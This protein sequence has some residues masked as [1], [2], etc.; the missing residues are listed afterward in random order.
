SDILKKFGFSSVKSASTPMETHKPLSKDAA[1]TDVDVH[2]YSD[3]TG[4]SLDRKSTTGGCQFLGLKLK[5]YLIN[6]GYANLVQHAGIFVN[7]SLTKKVFANRKRVGIGFF[8][9]V[10]PLFDTMMI[11]PVEEVGDLPTA[12]Q[13]TPIPNAPSS[14]Q[15]QRKHKPRRKEKKERKEIEVSPTHL[16]TE[17]PLPI[18]SNDLL[19]SGEDS[20]QLKELMILC[21]NLSNKVLDLE[22]KVIEMKSSHQAK[23]VVIESKVEKLEEENMSLTKELKS[24]NSKVESPTVKEIVVDK[25]KSSK[26]GM[27]IADIDADAEVNLENVYNLDMTYEETVLSM[28]D[29]TDVDGKEVAEEMVEVITTAKII[30]DEV[31]TTGGELNAANEEPISTAPINI[32][33]AQPSEATKKIIDITTAP[34]AKGIVFHDMEESTTRTASSK[35]HVKDKG[36]TKIKAKW[37]VDMQDNIDWNEVVEQIKALKKRTRKENVEKDQSAKRQKGDEIKKD[38]AEEQEMEEQQEAEELKRNLEIVPDDEDD[39]FVNV[40]PLA[41]KPLII[42]DYKIYKEG[43]QEHFQIIRA[44]GNHQMYLGFSTMLKN[45]D[46]ED[47]E[48]LWKIVKDIFKESQPK[49]VLDVFL[50]HT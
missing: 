1:G 8:K 45:F 50:W 47:L 14:S 12:D 49:E 10:T 31:S 30:V 33:T 28:H 29:A 21:T 7:P 6:D 25:E 32:T 38:N 22:N 44:N 19:P 35:A 43:K 27:K 34:K 2:L 40:A 26:Q 23:I 13:D 4:A 16:P 46:R 20:M 37:N 15:P 24:F 3:Y 36:K 9:V 42:M 41:S 18:T 5:G 48:V 17:D 39:V 11:Q